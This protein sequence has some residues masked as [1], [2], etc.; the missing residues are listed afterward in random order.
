[1][2]TSSQTKASFW[3][4]LLLTLLAMYLLLVKESAL[5]TA[6]A[7]ERVDTYDLV[8]ELSARTAEVR[9]HNLFTEWFVNSGA[10]SASFNLLIP[11]KVGGSELDQRADPVFVWIEG[12]V[13][14]I[15][16]VIY[17]LMMRISNAALWWPFII[18]TTIPF[19]VDAMVKRRI[20]ANTFDH[21]SPHVQSL[22]VKALVFALFGYPVLL[23][24]PVAIPAEALPMLI[25]VVAG[26]LSFAISHFVKRA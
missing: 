3:F 23:L 20:K 7:Q 11:K 8:G 19:V 24:V 17:Q 6:L 5:R 4:F 16:L 25:F 9:A 14:S 10:T 21:T 13:R 2:A 15:W 18:L 26:A 12:R 22:A 1:M